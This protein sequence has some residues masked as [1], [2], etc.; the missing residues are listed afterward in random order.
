MSCTD[1]ISAQLR[2]RGYRITP[3]RLAVLEALHR[4]GHLAAGEVLASVRRVAPRLTEAT[5]YRTL[6]F[7]AAQGVV[8]AGRDAEGRLCFELAGREHHH[9]ICRRCGA[10]VE[11]PHARVARLYRE[12]EA[13]T[14]FQ[15]SAS[16]LTL[17]G[18]CARCQKKKE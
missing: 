5:V 15:L 8:L 17:Q 11:I 3:Q 14:G 12:L 9:L 2:Q 7:L 6:E 1:R 10:T 18:L 16:H 13:E 4:G